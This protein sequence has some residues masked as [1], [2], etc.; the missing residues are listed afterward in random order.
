M[1]TLDSAATPSGSPGQGDT[2]P[3]GATAQSGSHAAV[4]TPATA[5]PV[6]AR[7]THAPAEWITCG[8]IAVIALVVLTQMFSLGL[9]TLSRPQAGLWPMMVSLIILVAIPFAVLDTSVAE[10]YRMGSMARPVLMAGSLLAF[11]PLYP[12]LGFILATFL[13]VF[14]ITRWVCGE[15][16]RTA[17]IVA[18]ATPLLTYLLFGVMFKVAMNPLPSWLIF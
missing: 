17:L 2:T 5:S 11:L 18:T 9:G 12:L 1:T 14:V 16:L 15:G 10:T 7:A 6:D 3:Q 4:E 13:T 8:A